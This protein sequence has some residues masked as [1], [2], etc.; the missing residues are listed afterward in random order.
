M[1]NEKLTPVLVILLVLA[2]FLGGSLWMRSKYDSSPQQAKQQQGE[3]AGQQVQQAPEFKP[4]K[5]DNPEVKFFVM[6]FCP[7][8]NQ[9]EDGLKPVAELLED[10]V[11]WEPVYIVSDA[12]E[13]CELG[14]ENSVFDEERCKQIIAGNPQQVPDMETCKKYFPYETEQVCLDEKCAEIQEG[15]FQSLHGDQELNQNVRELCA[16]QMGDEEKWWNF[17]DLV[18]QNCSYQNADECWEDYA[19]EAG[20]NTQAIKTCE[21]NQVEEILNEQIAL[22]KEYNVSGSPTVFINGVLYQGG[23]TPEAYKQA[24]CQSFIN[25]P[26]ECNENLDSSGSQAAP[27]PGTCN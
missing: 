18:N 16:W 24:I 1:L 22:T 3:A 9:A 17:I 14:C 8:G 23:R 15:E 11:A 13:S 20:F 21:A 25:E 6:S 5:T 7:Y 12:K 4:E 27:A 10:K 19:S 26:E 2:A